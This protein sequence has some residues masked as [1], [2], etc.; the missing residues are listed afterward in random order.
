MKPKYEQAKIPPS[1]KTPY[2]WNLRCATIL[3]PLMRCCKVVITLP[4][5][6]VDMHKISYIIYLVLPFPWTYIL[7]PLV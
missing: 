3:L 7:S 1:S 4:A 6:F 5:I 2:F